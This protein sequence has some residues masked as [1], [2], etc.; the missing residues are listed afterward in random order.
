MGV[1]QAEETVFA[2]FLPRERKNRGQG[3]L[4]N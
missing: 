2:K 3:R 4:G 1:F